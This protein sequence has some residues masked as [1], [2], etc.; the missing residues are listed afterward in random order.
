MVEVTVICTVLNEI[1][2]IERL[3]DSLLLQTVK[4][5]DIIFVDGGSNDGTFEILKNKSITNGELKVYKHVGNISQGRNFAIKKSR[6]ELI[7]SIDGGCYADS[8]WL[9]NL[10]KRYLETLPDII[11]GVYKPWY[12]S[13]FEHVQG[14]M[15]CPNIKK[16]HDE[17]FFAGAK[18]ILFKKSCWEMVGGFNEKLYTGEDTR[19]DFDMK[20]IGAVYSLAK[21]A[22]VYWRMRETAKKLWRQYFLYG[23]GDAKGKNYIDSPFKLLYAGFPFIVILYFLIVRNTLLLFELVAFIVLY[24][25]IKTVILLE[26]HNFRSIMTGVHIMIIR[27]LAYS[28]GFFRELLFKE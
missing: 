7:A 5:T 19:F 22:I 27:L 4:P 21:D 15:V 23:I 20:K 26:S 12:K 16:L 17:Q 11:S 24:L 2:T 9:K 6:T 8:E 3:V 13:D 14:K 28:S 18:N 25:V 10:I 1:G